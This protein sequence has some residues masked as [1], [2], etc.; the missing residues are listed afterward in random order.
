MKHLTLL[1]S[2]GL[3][4]V[5]MAWADDMQEQTAFPFS[6]TIVNVQQTTINVNENKLSAT[7]LAGKVQDL[8]EI[9]PLEGEEA[10]RFPV[11]QVGD[12][13]FD[14]A[15]DV[16]I[17]DAIGYGG[18]N[19]FYTLHLWDKATGK[20]QQYPEP[21]SNP[22]LDSGKKVLTSSQRSGPKWYTTKYQINAKG[23]L[24]PAV[25]WE[26]LSANEGAWEYLTF[27]NPQGKVT[28]HK[29]VVSGEEDAR[30][31]ADLPDATATIEVEKTHLY[32]AA[33]SPAPTKMYIIKGDKVTLLDWKPLGDD[34]FGDG[35]FLVRYKGHKV[36]E[37]WI[38]GNA[39]VKP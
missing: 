8:G 35:R 26:M 12:F 15:Q 16:A 39:L 1:A 6:F 11:A 38:D 25:E 33:D 22:A 13:N 30:A 29:I 17:Q 7:L 37:K 5:N 28:G 23:A 2:A 27:K 4:A 10:T 20:F 31:D 34:T 21:I 3:L 19:I 9:E 36:L 24:Y 18:V 32:E 14:G